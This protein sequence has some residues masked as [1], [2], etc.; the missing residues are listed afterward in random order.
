MKRQRV[1]GKSDGLD[2]DDEP[3]TCTADYS[4]GEEDRCIKSIEALSMATERSSQAAATLAPRFDVSRGPKGSLQTKR[5][6]LTEKETQTRYLN[7]LANCLGS[8]DIATST[9]ELIANFR[10]NKQVA[11]EDALLSLIIRSGMSQKGM[12]VLC[13]IGTGRYSRLRDGRPVQCCTLP[14]NGKEITTEELQFFELDV[15]TWIL[16]EGFPCAHRHIKYYVSNGSTWKK[17]WLEYFKR[18]TVNNTRGMAYKTWMQYRQKVFP[19][20]SLNRVKEDQCDHCIKLQVLLRDENTSSSD[21][22]EVCSSPVHTYITALNTIFSSFS[23]L[24]GTPAAPR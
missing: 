22:A 24:F 19:T 3:F 4:S 14:R 18:C 7:S 10:A 16:E 21:K 2:S 17:L 23:D 11:E 20:I 12:R 15:N 5:R 13:R 1:D 8:P 6:Q 9:L